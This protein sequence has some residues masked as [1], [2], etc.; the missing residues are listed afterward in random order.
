MLNTTK[1]QA[2]IFCFLLFLVVVSTAE[3]KIP[4]QLR[5]ENIGLKQTISINFQA[6]KED[7]GT[8][9][10]T[11]VVFSHES[12]SPLIRVQFTAKA[13]ESRNVQ[14]CYVL[15]IYFTNNIIPYHRPQE[16]ETTKWS[17]CLETTAKGTKKWQ[18]KFPIV[19]RDYI[20]NDISVYELELE[21]VDN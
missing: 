7:P 19:G 15:V 10:G 18:L 8:L 2:L 6:D 12:E 11:Y 20:I 1:A 3:A 5:V 16:I 14:N 9:N 13:T 17:L 4:N 21:Q